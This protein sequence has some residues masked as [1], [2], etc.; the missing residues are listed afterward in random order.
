MGFV[1]PPELPKQPDLIDPLLREDGERAS[2]TDEWSAHREC[3]K[4]TLVHYLYGEMPDRPTQVD[5]T[6]EEESPVFGGKA[7][8][9]LVKVSLEQNGH[10]AGLRVGLIV[11][12]GGG[13]FPIVIKN[14]AY[15]FGVSEVSDPKRREKMEGERRP[16]VEAGVFED[17]ID[18]G[19]AI[20]KFV[21]T[22]WAD[23][24]PESKDRGIYPLYPEC[25]WGAIAVWAWTFSVL[26]DWLSGD[27]EIDTDRVIVTGHSRGGKTALAAGILDE[28]IC[29]TAPNSSGGGGT[30]SFRFFKPGLREQRIA[31]QLANFPHWWHPRFFE[32]AE[33]E[34]HLPFDAHT[35]K[36]LVAPRLLFNAHALQD[37]W[38][39]PYGTQFS[40]EAAQCVYD[41]HGVPDRQGI[42]WREG[43]HAQAKID[44]EALLDFCDVHVKGIDRPRRFDQLP[45]K[46]SPE[47]QSI[48]DSYK[49]QF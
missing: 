25:D 24:V 43:G 11:P 20:C 13:P 33:R 19:Y 32:F 6:E 31:N 23:D 10:R 41:W 27:S 30:G 38:A 9:R 5:V 18:R 39:N 4:K 29:V 35:L 40:Y 21:R 48:L 28:R 17:A 44:W 45:F 37:D 47:H 22:D 42:H 1:D 12:E 3:L 15:R 7:T 36:A 14:D 8:R 49:A 2:S 26:V 34:D 46:Y 16:D